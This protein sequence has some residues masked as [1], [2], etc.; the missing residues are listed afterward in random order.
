MKKKLSCAVTYN[1]GDMVKAVIGSEKLL[2][3]RK[4]EIL[5]ETPFFG[6]PS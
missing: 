5:E 1:G 2:R 3:I 6:S 4:L